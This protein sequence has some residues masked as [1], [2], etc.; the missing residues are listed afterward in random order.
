MLARKVTEELLSNYKTQVL[1]QSELAT[2]FENLGFKE[3]I[4][5]DFQRFFVNSGYSLLFLYLSAILLGKGSNED[6][7]F[8]LY[9]LLDIEGNSYVSK[10]NLEN[11]IKQLVS[12]SIGEYCDQD[13]LFPYISNL[14]SLKLYTIR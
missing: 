8:C 6:K 2:L 11:A 1:S 10:S 9:S 13:Y 3:M 7:V 5:Q 4:F 14:R 12:L